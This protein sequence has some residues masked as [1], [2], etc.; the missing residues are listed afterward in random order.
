MLRSGV[1]VPFALTHLHI[2]MYLY[3]NI[4]IC[5][6]DSNNTDIKVM[7]FMFVSKAREEIKK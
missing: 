1:H 2:Y 6:Y 4:Y 7:W 5:L 3:I